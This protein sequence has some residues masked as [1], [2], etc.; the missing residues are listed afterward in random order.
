MGEAHRHGQSSLKVLALSRYDQT[1]ASSRLRFIQFAPYLAE[2]GIDV[3]IE[4]LLGADYLDDLYCGRGRSYRRLAGRYLHRVGMLFGEPRPDILWIEKEL[5]P[6]L[7]YRFEAALIGSRIPYVLDLDDAIFHNYDLGRTPLT[8]W[9]LGDKID[10]LMRHAHTVVVGNAY[11][12]ERARAAGARDV[13]VIPTVI[14]G[15]RYGVAKPSSTGPLT[16][17][18]IGSPVTFKYVKTLLPVLE[19][20]C[21]RTGGRLLL[22]GAGPDVPIVSWINAVPW[23]EEDEVTRLASIDIGIMPIP[24][25]L[26]E[27]GKCGYKLI[28]YMACGKPV[29]ASQVGANVEIVEEGVQGFLATDSEAWLER[30]ERLASDAALRQRMGMAGLERARKLYTIQAVV[31]RLAQV[32]F[33][34]GGR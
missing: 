12:A 17:G 25:G 18:W 33:S 30:L 16:I 26:W 1:G 31:P 21:R 28:Q 24:D 19:E 11:L 8:R 5:L 15:E 20:V 34:A 6:G 22:I 29:V 2:A 23:S 10:R 27:R 13:Q 32:L 14:D 4:P 3:Q 7:P 9:L